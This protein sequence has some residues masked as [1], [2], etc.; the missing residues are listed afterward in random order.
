MHTPKE[1]TDHRNDIAH[2]VSGKIDPSRLRDLKLTAL[3]LI[4]TKYRT[5][6]DG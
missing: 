1:L 4:R 3:E 5:P 2:W 6:N